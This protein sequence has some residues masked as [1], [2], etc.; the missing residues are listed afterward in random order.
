MP[1]IA[2]IIATAPV[3]NDVLVDQNLWRM[4]TYAVLA[5]LTTIAWLGREALKKIDRMSEL[6]N[7]MIT[8]EAVI[9]E[10]LDAHMADDSRHCHMFDCPNARK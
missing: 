6:I 7:T 10:R 4:S 1:D 9:V 3:A 2:S 8:K 5:L